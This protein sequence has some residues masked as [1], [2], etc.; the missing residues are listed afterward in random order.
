[1]RGRVRMLTLAAGPDGVRLPGE[2]WLVEEAEAFR[3][4]AGGYAESVTPDGWPIAPAPPPIT[5]P[6]TTSVEPPETATLP[7][8]RRNR[9]G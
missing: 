7:R 1:M 6:E 8:A 9:Q 4:I 5:G 3:L 2:T